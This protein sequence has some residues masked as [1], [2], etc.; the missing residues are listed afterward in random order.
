MQ[1][2]KA[3]LPK[4]RFARSVAVMGGGTAAASAIAAL[5]SPIVTR[6][7][8]PE[9]YGIL[10]VFASLTMVLLVMASWRYEYAIPV[11]EDDRLGADI[12]GLCLTIV[13]CM[14]VVVGILVWLIGN[15]VA[16][17]LHAPALRGYLWLFPVSLLVGGTYQSLQY[18]AVRKKAFALIAQTK[19]YQA[20]G[21]VGTQLGLGLLGVRPLGLLLGNIVQQSAG[22]VRLA[23]FALQGGP[24][25]RLRFSLRTSFQ[26]AKR[27]YRFPLFSSWASLLNTCSAQIPTL[28]FSAFFGSTVT[29]HYA[30][31][32]QVVWYPMNLIGGAV[33][34]VFFSSAS[35][36]R[37]KGTTVAVTFTVFSRLLEVAVPLVLILGLV[38]PEFFGLVFGQKWLEAGVFAQWLCPWLFLVFITSPLSS[39]VF[40]MERQY[41]EL[42]FQFA[43]LVGR[44]GALTL[45]GYSGS[46]FT[47]IMLYGTTSGVIWFAYMLW[48]L[49]MTGNRPVTAINRIGI[50][51]ARALPV[52]APC[53]LGK[54][55]FGG[56]PMVAA[57][58][59][60]SAGWAGF[61]ILRRLRHSGGQSE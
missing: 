5:A 1:K 2:V 51:L 58:T 30:L 26:T 43:L 21:L 18:W 22:N 17:W 25:C 31:C 28:F 14:S 50:E 8:A 54:F 56:V 24:D 12:L 4:G 53:A 41:G 7:Y 19:F 9:D 47:A 40:V 46:P 38:A 23:R 39:M 20:L 32:S 10:G 16:D 55:V 45:G 34:Q 11:P 13:P 33:S 44:L 49:R 27:Y 60:I 15:Q 57:G 35:D 59:I 3:L 52:V 36:A 42:V 48:L 29:G 6:L 61:R 37:A